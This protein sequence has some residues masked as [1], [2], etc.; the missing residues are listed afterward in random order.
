MPA[1]V[2]DVLLVISLDALT[3]GG[4]RAASVLVPRGLERVLVMAVLVAAA[5]VIESLALGLA[6]LSG[7][8]A[9]LTV[10]AVLTWTGARAGLPAPAASPW[11]ELIGWWSELPLWA[12]GAVGAAA[13]LALALVANILRR[14]EPGFDG[15]TYHLPEV[16]AFVQS[17]HAGSVVTSNYTLPV[18]TTRS[19]TRSCCRG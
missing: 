10:L 18:G 15:I 9:A 1:F 16:V 3:A 4:T 17:G 11:D 13:G 14:P 2:L 8:P 7:S 6:G 12:R 5:A 19:P